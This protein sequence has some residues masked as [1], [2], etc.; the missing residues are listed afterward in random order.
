MG[1][2]RGQDGSALIVALLMLAVLALLG[3]N[4]VNTSTMSL[5]IVSNAQSQADAEAAAQDAIEQVISSK[6]P[7]AAPAAA[8]VTVSRPSYG[9]EL[10]VAVPAAECLDAQ[11][12][13]GYSAVFNLAP[14][15]TVW[16]VVASVVDAPTGARAEIHQGIEITM[17]QGSCP[18]P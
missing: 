2:S 17:I 8:T 18:E 6:D 16:E 13:K 15:A 4:A 7:F 11:T 12:A 10:D 3:V 14:E 5:R 9:D 1:V